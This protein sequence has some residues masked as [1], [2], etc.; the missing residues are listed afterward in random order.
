MRLE[1]RKRI[2]L[3]GW[4]PF[5][6]RPMFSDQRPD[7]WSFAWLFWYVDSLS[8]EWLE[9]CERKGCTLLDVFD[10]VARDISEGD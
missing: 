6:W 7:I 9:Y 4:C 8:L 3:V 2:W 5:H 1:T 10:M